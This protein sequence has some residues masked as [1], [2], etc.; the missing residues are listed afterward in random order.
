MHHHNGKKGMVLVY[1]NILTKFLE[2][3][4]GYVA[5]VWYNGVYLHLAI[6]FCV[7]TAV[8]KVSDILNHSVLTGT[9]AIEMSTH[10]PV[11]Y[12]VATKR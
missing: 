4:A 11:G 9:M 12:G 1:C 2:H 8:R 7:K 6:Y 10:C 5:S 3:W